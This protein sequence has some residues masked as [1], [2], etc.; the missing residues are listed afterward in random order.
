[1]PINTSLNS[2]DIQITSIVTD[3]HIHVIALKISQ[4]IVNVLRL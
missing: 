1:M 3:P 2:F 4:G